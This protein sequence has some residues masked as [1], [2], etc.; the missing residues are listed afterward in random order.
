ML[1]ELITDYWQEFLLMASAHALAVASP[2]PDF[3]IVMRQSLV[4]GRR[5]AILTSI[6]IG[7]AILVHVTY[8][9]LG[10]GLLIRDTV[11][12]F[13]TI[14]IAGAAYLLYIG[15]QAIRVQKAE[16]K[17]F[18]PVSNDTMSNV[19]AF[20]QGFITNVLNP[21]ATLFFLSLFTTIVSADTPMGIQ[22]MYGVWMSIMTGV[23]FVFLSLML[24][25]QRVRQFFASFGHWI[26]RVLG[27]F[28]IILAIMLLFST[29]N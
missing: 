1:N 7:L 5:F 12:L 24:T 14:K 27:A 2:G 10:I 6:G 18:N 29:V 15:W 9:V 3:A 13:T 22:A 25:Q 17:D 26:D 4:F 20:R 8:A 28:L 16:V 11:W 21:K 19:K 23:W